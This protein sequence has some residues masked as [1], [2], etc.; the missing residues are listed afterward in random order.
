MA[1]RPQDAIGHMGPVGPTLTITKSDS[2]TYSPPL[3]GLLLGVAGAI[4]V[5]YSDG[6]QDT[7]AS[8]HLAAGVWH[9]LYDITKVL[10]TGTD[11]TGIH[12]GR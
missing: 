5:E 3:R 2:T 4:V 6:T 7:F 8:G 9:P 11:A 1:G 10:S 12:A